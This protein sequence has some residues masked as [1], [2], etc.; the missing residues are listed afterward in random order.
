MMKLYHYDLTI[1]YKKGSEMLLADTLSRQHVQGVASNPEENY[2]SKSEAEFSNNLEEINQL[3]ASESTTTELHGE[4]EK[5]G[6][7]QKLKSYIQAGWLE[8]QKS[9]PSNLAPYYH[10]RD[11]LATQDGLL[12]RGDRL[13]IPKSL[14]KKTH[15]GLEATT[16]RARKA[17]YWPH[18]NQELKDHISAC[19]TCD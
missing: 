10:I 17:V 2:P 13:I 1:V 3:L 18:L 19:E 12:F 5:D 8:K 9:I 14:R 6:D 4:N 7:L 15:Q 11:E 16:G